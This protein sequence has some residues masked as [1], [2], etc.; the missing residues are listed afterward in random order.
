MERGRRIALIPAFEPDKKLVEIVEKL[1][2]G[3]FDIVIVNDGSGSRFQKVFDCCRQHA[4]V[5]AHPDNRGKGIALKTGLQY[6]YENYRRPYTVVTLD[7]DGQHKVPDVCRACGAAE[8]HPGTLIL[9]SRTFG[10]NVPFKSRL[11]NGITRCVYMI[12]SGT[13]IYDTQTGLR[14]FTDC[15]LPE[16]L[17]ISGER[18]EYEMNV[19]M[20][21]AKEHRPMKEVKIET[22]YLENNASSHFDPCRDSWRIYREIM[23]FLA[24]SLIS[25]GIDYALYCML[26]ACSGSLM[27]SN[28]A[29]RI[30]SASANF[31][32]NRKMV[33]RGGA[34]L[35]KAAARYALL[36][37]F[38]L[39]CDTLLLSLLVWL[40][41]GRY[42]A[43]I[44]T[45]AMLF[46]A[47]WFIQ[48]SIV[49]IQRVR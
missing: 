47:S 13:R 21:F 19:L 4:R 11:G 26:A 24:S 43:K 25:F 31:M 41:L 3:S 39:L 9:G 22:V 45:E 38:I 7:A 48:R 1:K 8:I 32:M 29:A 44:L 42:A 15:L 30:V 36:A 23:R 5:I 27:A 37:I 12:F 6:I 35:A 20:H 46:L 49:F 33:F 2:D 16:L 18:Y 17:I 14:A 28:I 34:P 10:R 40:G